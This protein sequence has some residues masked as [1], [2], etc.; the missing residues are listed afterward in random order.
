LADQRAVLFVI[1]IDF[2]DGIAATGF[3][4]EARQVLQIS[5]KTH[6]DGL[7]LEEIVL[8]IVIGECDL[9]W[10]VVLVAKPIF[11]G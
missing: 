8:W 6:A 5:I 4:E 3:P 1:V 2:V 10:G 7:V 9:E 11:R